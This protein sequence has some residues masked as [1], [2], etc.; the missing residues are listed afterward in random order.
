MRIFRCKCVFLG[1]TWVFLSVILQHF[2][3][4]MPP[5]PPRMVVLKLICD[6]TSHDCD[7][8]WPPLG[9]FLRTPLTLINL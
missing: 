2:P 4:G 5:D 7:E 3:G 1:V 6:V 8:T 9:N